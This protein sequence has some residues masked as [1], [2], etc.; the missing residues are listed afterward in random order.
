[1]KISELI[2]Q[3]QREMQERG[4]LPVYCFGCQDETSSEAREVY[5]SDY[6]GMPRVTVSP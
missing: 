2:E 4:D 1:M 6:F 5:F 3:L